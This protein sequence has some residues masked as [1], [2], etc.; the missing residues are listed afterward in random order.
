MA[1]QILPPAVK[2]G[3]ASDRTNQ[4]LIELIR[5]GPEP[6]AMAAAMQWATAAR[7]AATTLVEKLQD[8][9]AARLSEAITLPKLIV[10]MGTGKSDEE[11][12]K[13][14]LQRAV[15]QLIGAAPA[16]D[17]ECGEPLKLT[18][19]DTVAVLSVVLHNKISRM[20]TALQVS[21]SAFPSLYTTYPL[22][23]QPD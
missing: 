10:E 7:D 15:V 9:E 13:C 8:L 18:A 1:S 12:R 2:L 5:K 23:R 22:C 20:S 16:D 4:A 21:H 19:Y 17:G 3:Y 14:T 11:V 6:H